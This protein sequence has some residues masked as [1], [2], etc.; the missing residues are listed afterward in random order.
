MRMCTPRAL[1]RG[2]FGAFI[3]GWQVRE[4]HE[5]RRHSVLFTELFTEIKIYRFTERHGLNH[6][7]RGGGGVNHR[8]F[9]PVA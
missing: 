9:R 2:N 3:I 4:S 8:G 6:H 5:V 1:N 7:G